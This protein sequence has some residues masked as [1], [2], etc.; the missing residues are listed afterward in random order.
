MRRSFRFLAVLACALPLACSDTSTTP[1]ATV[2]PPVP[3]LSANPA[4]NGSV[5][6]Y[7]DDW[8][9]WWYVA[10]YDPGLDVI[11]AITSYNMVA[12]CAGG[13]PAVLPSDWKVVQS[14]KF[15]N[16]YHGIAKM[17]EM[18]VFIYDGGWDT[19]GICMPPI[20]RGTGTAR[21]TDSDRSP[22]GVPAGNGA[23]A[24]GVMANGQVTDG[25]GQ[26]YRYSGHVRGVTNPDGTYKEE[27]S[28][29]LFPIK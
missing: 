25:N 3:S 23:R 16:L 29:N 27:L 11:G 6:I 19:W 13:D 8:V 26:A 17:P 4:S 22:T 20:M 18:Y 24:W 28:I 7:F 1:T 14:G 15:E 5:I 12:G 9:G 2:P 10:W 21:L